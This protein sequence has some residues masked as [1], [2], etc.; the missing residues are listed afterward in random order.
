[1]L[2]SI[3]RV[4]RLLRASPSSWGARR[5]PPERGQPLHACELL[6]K[7]TLLSNIVWTNRGSATNDSDQFNAVFGANANQARLVADAA[8][9]AWG[10][11]VSNLNLSNGSNELDVALTEYPDPGS[12]GNGGVSSILNGKP[13]S[14]TISLVGS[15]YFLD[16]TP[17]DSSEFEGNIINAFVG[18]ASAGTPAAAKG[19][20]FTVVVL[21]MAHVLGFSRNTDLKLWTSGM[22]TQ[23]GITIPP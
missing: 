7:R 11:V 10:R 16:P 19:D 22:L 5:P 15:D 4:A 9:A 21:E 3:N 17:S 1:M 2:D 18:E 12:G 14:G 13:T 23:T 20:Y 6:E 8:F